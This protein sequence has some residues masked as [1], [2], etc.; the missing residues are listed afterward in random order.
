MTAS[1]PDFVHIASVLQD[2]DVDHVL[3]GG[4][5]ARFRGAERP[6]QDVDG[7]VAQDP[8]NLARVAAALTDLDASLRVVSEFPGE[9][10]VVKV[11]ITAELLAQGQTQWW[12]PHG[13]VDILPYIDG[14]DGPLT[15]DDML[16]RA[17]RREVDG[18]IVTLASLDDVIASKAV[19]N[20]PKDLE[21][22]D[23]L[24]QIRRRD[25]QHLTPPP[26][27]PPRS[28]AGPELGF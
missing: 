5:S 8:G 16:P 3:V 15:Y 25:E 1:Q 6:T 7:V 17:D 26:A 12:T 20:R 9:S 10:S 23:E 13:N 21:A 11:R 24:R 19:S 27:P 22:L 18:V 14:P 2:H 4:A 28:P